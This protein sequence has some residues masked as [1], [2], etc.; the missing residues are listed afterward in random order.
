MVAFILKFLANKPYLGSTPGKHAL[1]TRSGLQPTSLRRRL[2]KRRA[3]PLSSF[4]PRLLGLVCYTHPD[5]G[6]RYGPP[7]KPTAAITKWLC[8][9]K[10]EDAVA[11]LAN[12][13]NAVAPT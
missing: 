12:S 7:P 4:L 3:G 10:L 6:G 5:R 9:A 13:R 1:A 11:Y 8:K 2:S